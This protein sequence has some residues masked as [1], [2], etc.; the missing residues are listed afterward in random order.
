MPV[1]WSAAMI[2]PVEDL[3]GAP[4]LRTEFVLDEGH[5]DVAEARAATSP[6]S[7]SSRPP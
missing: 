5:G 4:L 6:P 7:V 1:Q 2:S 3:D